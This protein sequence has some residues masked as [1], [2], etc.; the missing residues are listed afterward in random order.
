ML[1]RDLLRFDP[2]ARLPLADREVVARHARRLTIPG[3][4]WLLRPGR[5]L[6]DHYFLLKG[7]VRLFG[8][9]PARGSGTGER[10]S[11]RSR[12]ARRAIYPGADG[13]ASETLVQI[14]VVDPRPLAFLG[15]EAQPSGQPCQTDP[16][17]WLTRFLAGGVMRCLP[18]DHWQRALRGL[19]AR[20]VAAG[21]VIVRMGEPGHRFYI[22]QRG[23]AQVSRG[24][25]P[26]AELT[27]GD[28]FGEDALI[29]DGRRRADVHML[30][31]GVLSEMAAHDFRVVLMDLAVRT[32][33][34]STGATLLNVGREP[35]SGIVQH[36]PAD[37]LRTVALPREPRYLVVGAPRTEAALA[38]FILTHRGYDAGVLQ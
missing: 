21:E 14:L 13:V 19:K 5:Q 18:S 28:F 34:D 22:V 20:P 36:W 10:V 16:E 29:T 12:R 8:S 31:A 7:H 3:G 23:R 27:A 9:D 32:V 2:F 4:R 38:A 11:S 35:M 26:L 15:T 33:S 24:G 6:H 37:A 30:E 1:C 17:P 25:E